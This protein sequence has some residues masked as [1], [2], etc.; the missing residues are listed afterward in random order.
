MACS[1]DEDGTNS[2]CFTGSDCGTQLLNM[3]P[4]GANVY[5]HNLTYDGRLMAMYGVAPTVQKG[6]RTC[7]IAMRHEGKRT[8]LKDSL[9]LLQM[10]LRAFPQAFGL[11]EA[12]KE[13][14]PYNYYSRK[15][16]QT[17]RPL[18]VISEVGYNEV[19][20]WDD[21]TRQNS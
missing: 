7:T 4:D 2:G 9:G 21:S 12:Q 19:P 15:R 18:G 3:L 8:Y 5:F 13:V 10:P 20:T 6:S 1:A 17:K 11:G 14:F 16:L